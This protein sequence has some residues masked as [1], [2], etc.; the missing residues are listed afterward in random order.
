MS[1]NKDMKGQGKQKRL[2]VDASNILDIDIRQ[3]KE[4]DPE[5]AAILKSATKAAK[6]ILAKRKELDKE[7]KQDQ[8]LFVL[9]GENHWRPAQRLHHILLLEALKQNEETMTVAYEYEYNFAKDQDFR[10]YVAELED[11]KPSKV[12]EYLDFY[13][14]NPIGKGMCDMYVNMSSQ[15]MQSNYAMRTL[16]TYL[17]NSHVSNLGEFV[18][19]NSDAA[20]TKKDKLSLKDEFTKAC[21]K[22]CL[23]KEKRNV[24]ITSPDG[25]WVR[26]VH[27]ASKLYQY[28]DI[29]ESRIAVQLC[30]QTHVNGDGKKNIPEK[31]LRGVFEAWAQPVFSVFLDGES[32]EMKGIK[33][34]DRI[35]GR[36]LPAD[37]AF[38]DPD[39]KKK[40]QDYTGFSKAD[41]P[42][43]QSHRKE[44]NFVN[45][46]LDSMGLSYLKIE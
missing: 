7:G 3:V 26:N 37:E 44:K 28:A 14:D 32:K 4:I 15:S 17:F 10:E 33:T 23:G 29:Q 5:A 6:K 12:D 42:D 24:S 9:A 22:A 46:K 2:E 19:L 11:V 40:D 25:M 1:K 20:R 13:T 43:I 27:M 36:G 18:A 34:K 30:G 8:T 31:S 45:R 21:V 38:Y 41:R 39:L 16:S 35:N